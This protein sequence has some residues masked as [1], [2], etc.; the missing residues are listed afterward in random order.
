MANDTDFSS[1]SSLEGD[2]E[3][4]VK[5]GESSKFDYGVLGVSP[6]PLL[7]QSHVSNSGYS[8]QSSK[9]LEASLASARSLVDPLTKVIPWEHLPKPDRYY[10]FGPEFLPYISCMVKIR[11]LIESRM[12]WGG[13]GHCRKLTTAVE[14]YLD[15]QYSYGLSL[16]EGSDNYRDLFKKRAGLDSGMEESISVVKGDDVV[17]D[18]W[19]GHYRKYVDKQAKKLGRV[20]VNIANIPYTAGPWDIKRAVEQL[21]GWEGSVSAIDPWWQKGSWNHDGTVTLYMPKVAANDLVSRC[22]EQQLVIRPPRG[23]GGPRVIKAWLSKGARAG[24]SQQ[25]SEGSVSESLDHWA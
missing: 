19:L 24:Y 17:L 22:A 2:Y 21:L 11:L 18:Q 1:Q 7:S 3:Y 12:A 14:N 23:A 13:A 16:W 10:N 8:S 5:E 6:A 20:G 25:A 15:S 4:S 9:G